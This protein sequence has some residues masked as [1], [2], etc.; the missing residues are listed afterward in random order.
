MA[1]EVSKKDNSKQKW[2]KLKYNIPFIAS[3]IQYIMYFL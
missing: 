1:A 2:Q 3:Y